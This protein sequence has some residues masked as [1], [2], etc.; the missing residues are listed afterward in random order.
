MQTHEKISTGKYDGVFLVSH[1]KNRPSFLIFFFTFLEWFGPFEEF[2][3]RVAKN[4]GTSRHGLIRVR[5]M[6]RREKKRNYLFI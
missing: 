4:Q 6:E 5:K 1:Y 3:E 2:H